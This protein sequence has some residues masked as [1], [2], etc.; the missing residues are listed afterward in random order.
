M[1][2]IGSR[3][4]D[5]WSCALKGLRTRPSLSFIEPTGSPLHGVPCQSDPLPTLHTFFNP[6]AREGMPHGRQQ[7]PK[8]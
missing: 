2:E 1:T 8:A 7:N 6:H 5:S 3:L 4:L